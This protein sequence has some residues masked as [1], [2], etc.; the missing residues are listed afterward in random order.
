MKKEKKPRV[1]FLLGAGAS[2][3][4]NPTSPHRMPSTDEITDFILSGKNVV[5]HGDSHYYI[6]EELFKNP[7]NTDY[8]TWRIRKFLKYLK[9]FTNPYFTERY[10]RRTNYE[11]L[12]HIVQQLDDELMG[13]FDNPVI[14]SFLQR[15]QPFMREVLRIRDEYRDIVA[16]AP[17]NLTHET[18][19]LVRDVLC[20]LL[21]KIPQ[22]L[23]GLRCLGQASSD[24]DF[25]G[26]DIFTFN[27]DRV[28]ETYLES[29][30]IAY[31]AGFGDPINHIRHW[32]PESYDDDST[33]VR[34]FKLHGSI[35]WIRFSGK[36]R[37]YIGIPV[38]GDPYNRVDPEGRPMHD[39]R[40][41]VLLIGTLNK[42][43]GY[44]S[45]P[46]LEILCYFR[47]SL[48]DLR[49]L[50]I[51]G[52]GFGDEGINRR[53]LE[54]MGRDDKFRLLIIDRDKAILERD[55]RLSGLRNRISTIIVDE[56]Q[57]LT[58][59]EIKKELA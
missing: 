21:W 56:N 34:L 26:I 15:L 37:D 49:T 4:A 47:P 40:R 20:E 16:N 19:Q 1:V 18:L 59:D 8:W 38:G 33:R 29:A 58:W 6:S 54:W 10:G 50:V 32:N 28:L 23:S 11:D 45:G 43:I 36:G 57:P 48:F 9:D 27:H 30:K 22:D 13:E 53:I 44:T 3:G 17:Q 2:I 25:G 31:Y 35:D 7:G 52:Y 42:I 39:W 55:S 46:F 14:Q 51:Y 24:D 41:V 5:R 12:F